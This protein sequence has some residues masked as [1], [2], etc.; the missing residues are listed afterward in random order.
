MTDLVT[1][2][3]MLKTTAKIGGGVCLAVV[4]GVVFK[5]VQEDVFTPIDGPAFQPW[6]DWKTL[7]PGPIGLAQ[8][9]I[10][11]SNPHNTQPWRFLIQK[12]RI[13]VFADRTRHLGS[14][15]PYRREMML[16]LGC[17]IENLCLAAE[18]WGISTDVEYT[19]GTL[20]L[21]DDNEG[22]QKVASIA[23]GESRPVQSALFDA[24]PN[25]HT[26]RFPYKNEPLADE[27]LKQMTALADEFDLRL[28]LFTTGEK[29]TTFDALMNEATETIVADAEMIH[30][31]H[32][33]FRN[34]KSEVEL[35]RDGP[36]MDGVGIPKWMAAAAKM[37]PPTDAETA[38]Q[39]WVTATRDK[40]L[41][42][43]PLVGV[44][45]LKN[46]FDMQTTLQA[47]RF[48]QRLHLLATTFGVAA[49][50]MNQPNE[51]MDR[52]D[53]LERPNIAADKIADLIETDQWQSTFN[54]R[55]GYSTQPAVSSPRRAL[56]DRLV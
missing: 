11:A 16:G 35:H 27:F 7:Q 18:A 22:I 17:A 13:D 19:A 41:K 9:A 55:M 53:Q 29:R 2:R 25:R 54:F 12:D 6:A 3:S 49:Q 8:V 52:L 56:T 50:P 14:F 23:L 48:W 31:S 21:A 45:S 40:H 15:D 5:A 37:L 32:R 30:D 20:T 46:R 26:N 36:F 51:W 28:D 39:M 33:W 43:A 10:L 44:I 38:H 42:N 4:G 24:I 1:R 34:N 47:G